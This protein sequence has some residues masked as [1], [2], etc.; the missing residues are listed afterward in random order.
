MA[1]TLPSCA[2]H[3]QAQQDPELDRHLTTTPIKSN[4]DHTHGED[5]NKIITE[6]ETVLMGKKVGLQQASVCWSLGD[7]LGRSSRCAV[8]RMPPSGAG[9]RTWNPGLL[10]SKI[11]TSLSNSALGEKETMPRLKL[12]PSPSPGMRDI[13]GKLR[14]TDGDK[15]SILPE[16]NVSVPKVLSSGRLWV[17]FGFSLGHSLSQANKQLCPRRGSLC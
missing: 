10:G 15:Q 9:L 11:R 3:T 14:E 13:S 16:Q 12:S 2:S 8:M 17:C 7:I 5:L 4:T 1:A 6:A